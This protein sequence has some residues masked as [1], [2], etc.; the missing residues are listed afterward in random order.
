MIPIAAAVCFIALLWAIVGPW[1]A[2]RGGAVVRSAGYRKAVAAI[3]AMERS[4]GAAAASSAGFRAGWA[5]VT[6]ELPAGTPLAGYGDRKGRPS[7][8]AHD[9]IR[10][11]AA[12]FGGRGG[13]A[14]IAGSDLLI[15]PPNVADAV[16]RAV[17]REIP[18][19]P[20]R[21]L[22]GAS[23]TH[24]GP[25]GAMRGLVARLFAGRFDAA[26]ERAVVDAFTRAIL[27][28][29]ADRAP[30]EFAAAVLE[31]PDLIRNR[32]REATKAAALTDTLLHAAFLRQPATG[33]L[34][35]LARYSAHATVL[36]AGN[37]R[38]SADYPG[39][40]QA[41]LERQTGGTA[42]Y[43]GGALGSMGPRPPEGA[44][45]FVRAR[46]MGE[47][48]ARRI[49]AAPDLR[50]NA[51]PEVRAMSVPVRVPS[52]QLR[53]APAWRLSPLLLRMA[54]IRS[55]VSLTAVRLGGTAWI[56]F[57]CDLSGEIAPRIRERARS[58][59]LDV[60]CTGFN[61]GYVGYVS[62]D[63]YYGEVRDRK[64][65]LAYET[66][67]MSWCGPDQ[68]AFFTGIAERLIAAVAR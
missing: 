27:E 14:V 40:L 36:G 44:D 19:D 24:S 2:Y 63:A 17:A 54:G 46:A 6:V 16:R 13:D 61:G 52:L 65:G 66:D 10:V 5:S 55:D 51:D 47:D 43:L 60:V 22:F 68:E 12:A 37:M 59:G 20:S 8:G 41:A 15:V 23:H 18:L 48:L 56:G 42:V 32:T 34:C 64:G 26:V 28:A 38:F 29:W 1:P 49:L 7:E 45:G 39:F 58:L 31:A 9:P 3:E 11:K 25:G 30:A 21:I 53:I 50:F 57:P 4:A 33:R 67:I 62:P 35:I